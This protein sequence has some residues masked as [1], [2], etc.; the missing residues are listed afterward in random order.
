MELNKDNFK[1][2]IL[3]VIATVFIYLGVKNIYVILKAIRSFIQFIFPFVLGAIFAFILNVPMRYFEGRARA[4]AKKY[5]WKIK[6]FRVVGFLLTLLLVIGIILVILFLVIP[7]LS[8]TLKMLWENRT[9]Y[10]NGFVNRLDDVRVRVP[11]LRGLVDSVRRVKIDWEAVGKFLLSLQNGEVGTMVTSTF[12]VISNVVASVINFLIA[13]VF[14]CYIL[15]QKEHLSE[16]GKMLLYAALPEK[17]VTCIINLGKLIDD[18]FSRFI[19]GQCTEALILGSMFMVSMLIFRMPFAFL[20]GALVSVT[21]L[22]PIV[23][24]T[25]AC[26]VGSI[27]M[28]T[29]SPM[30]MVFFIILFLALQQIEGHFIY[31]NVVGNSIG[32]PALWV[33]LALTIGAKLF[34]IGGMLIGIPTMSVIYVL[35][36]QWIQSNLKKKG[37]DDEKWKHV[38][39]SE[40]D[41]KKEEKIRQRY[42]VVIKIPDKI[43]TKLKNVIEIDRKGTNEEET[44]KDAKEKKKRMDGMK[45]K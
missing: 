19:I 27:L 26:V 13:L 35:I 40:E 8:S 9:I 1:K 45:K 10:A 36:D 12:D 11:M 6:K 5:N 7:E 42:Q 18:T 22:I 14:A 3:L 23:G 43:P 16:Q 34:G 25:L 17:Y 15:F 32:L 31:P 38:N 30:Q 37:I 29:V 33:L 41:R 4:L 44:E 20:I 28:L 24:S 39:R 21:A 2:L